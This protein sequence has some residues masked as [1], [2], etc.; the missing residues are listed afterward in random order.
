[1]RPYSTFEDKLADARRFQREEQIPWTVAVDDL[2]GSVHRAYGML[3]DPIYLI[4][5]DGRVAFYNYW[6]HVPTVHRA[7]ERLEAAGGAAA[8]GEHRLPHPLATLTDGWRALRRGLPQS[9]TDLE[10]AMPGMASGPWFGYQLRGVLAP[11]A[12]TSR[13]WPAKTRV[14]AGLLALAGVAAGAALLAQS[15]L[16]GSS[17]RRSLP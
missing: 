10:T 11:I 6:T 14:A 1:M 2:E 8:I 16:A 5:A 3:A 15:R 17:D 12:L 9:F 4:G 7:I 13:P